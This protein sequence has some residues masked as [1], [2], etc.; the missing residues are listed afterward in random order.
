MFTYC[1]IARI[2]GMTVSAMP[3]TEHIAERAVIIGNEAYVSDEYARAEADKLWSKVWQVACREEEIPN[4]G[5]F[6]TYDIQDESI[7]VVRAAADRIAAYYNVCPHRARKLAEG[8]GHI[9]RFVCKF[10]AWKFDLDGNNVDVIRR[11][12]WNGALRDEHLRLKS[13]KV[14][15]WGGYVFINMDPECQPLREYLE[16]A[17]FYLDP[18][19]LE[20]MRYR[21]RQWLYFPCNWKVA[22]EAFNESYHAFGTHPQL[23][24]FSN[25]PSWSEARGIHGCMGP[26]VR[27][28]V[29][30]AS[31]GAAGAP[32]MRVGLAISLNQ[33]WEEVN[34]TTTETMVKVANLLVDEL[35]EGT[36]AH[37]VQMHFMKRS[38]EEDAKRGVTWPTIDPAHIKAAGADWHIFP[39]T[40]VIQGPTF[41]LGYRSRPNGFD[42]NSCIFEV[43]TLERFPEGQAPKTE[44]L[45]RPGID[46]A[47]WRK[48]L[49]QDFNNMGAVQKGLKSR[50][51]SGTRPGPAEEAAVINFHRVLARYMGTGMPQPLD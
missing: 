14:D 41:V 39:N 12:G 23:M 6:V 2:R 30:G 16:P 33:L 29:G 7:I 10:H 5:D 47:N 13:V 26:L 50:G 11:E 35:P 46:E 44:N 32:D 25:K 19:E 3:D 40:V 24:R 18:Y 27:E 4:T 20:K 17:A 34:G 48:V 37:E 31:M 8:C 49:C 43:Y 42:P 28:G 1:P 22:I 21:W 38:I 51:F 45:F 9:T 36:P 15:T